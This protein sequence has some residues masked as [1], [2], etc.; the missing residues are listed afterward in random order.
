M[1]TLIRFSL[2]LPPSVNQ[3]YATVNGRRVL[4][5]AARAW[6]AEARLAL[7]GLELPPA[8]QATLRHGYVALFLDVYF[9]TP[10]R[11]DLDG[12]LKITLDAIC[13]ALGVDDR[14][15]VDIHLLKR[16]DPLRPRIE[17]ELEAL[18]NWQFDETRPVL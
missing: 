17:V 8:L 5:R 16:I 7:S 11:R 14:R 6:R 9:A 3:Q 2:P 10:L 4:S 12:G 18:A 13:E 15:V 1:S